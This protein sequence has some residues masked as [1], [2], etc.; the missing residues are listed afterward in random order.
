M[1]LKRFIRYYYLKFTRLKGDSRALA[2]GAAIGAFMAVMPI[3]PVRT[4]VLIAS[5][6]FVQ[7][8]TIA[9][10]IMATVISNPLTYIPLYYGAV[11]TGNALTPYTLNWERVE[12]VLAVMISNE[13]F[14]ASIQAF[15]SLGLEA[16]IVLIVGGIALA[17]PVGLITYSLSLYFFTTRKTAKK[18]HYL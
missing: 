12:K 2:R 15:A 7:A 5:T 13:G 11:I 6:V 9:A 8:S 4:M 16:F 10:L 14:N 17:I 1:N 3:M 18:S